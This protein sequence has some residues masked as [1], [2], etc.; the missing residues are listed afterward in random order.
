MH[1]DPRSLC[2]S[3]LLRAMPLNLYYSLI[4]SLPK[5]NI[6][7]LLELNSGTLPIS[8]TDP[9]PPL[10]FDNL[11]LAETPPTSVSLS[12]LL[13]NLSPFTA[14]L[15]SHNNRGPIKDPTGHKCP[16]GITFF[17]PNS[18]SSMSKI[19]NLSQV[20][21]NVSSSDMSRALQ[22]RVQSLICSLEV[23]K[24]K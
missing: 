11:P 3:M 14:K 9:Y 10:Y 22:G 12:N 19:K 6:S 15:F 8:I 20:L 18:L 16:N 17:H 21:R 23:G 4:V 24:G 2:T 1:L 7:H 5:C 13:S